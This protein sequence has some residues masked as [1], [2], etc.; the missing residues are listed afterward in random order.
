MPTELTP[1]TGILVGLLV[2]IVLTACLSF[3]RVARA[4]GKI[5]AVLFMGAGAGLLTWGLLGVLGNEPFEP[6]EMGPIVFHNASQ[7]LGWGGGC[8]VGGITGLVLAFVGRR[9]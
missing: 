3:P 4:L 5:A 6:M 7:A 9:D 8:L 1:M 2:G